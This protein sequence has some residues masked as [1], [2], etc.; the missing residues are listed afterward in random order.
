MPLRIAIG[1]FLHET[2]TFVPPVTPWARFVEPGAWPGFVR[3][4][5]MLPRIEPY[6]IACAGFMAVARA[7]GHEVLPLAWCMAQPSGRVADEAFERVSAIFLERIDAL[8]PDVVFLELHGAMCTETI[9]DAEGELQRRVRALVGPDV[10]ILV[11][12]DLHANVTALMVETASFMSA[13]RTYPHIDWLD[14]GARC[15]RWL[16]AVR[17][18]GP[19]PPRAFRQ[20]PFLIPIASG[21]STIEPMKGLYGLLETIERET[22]VHLSLCPGFPSADIYDSGASV[23][24]YGAN[25]AIVDQAVDR[26]TQAVIKAEPEFLEH[27]ARPL[28]DALD[29]AD[30]RASGA[31]KPILIADSQDNPGG[32]GSSATT[33]F[34]QAM[35]ARSAKRALLA[36][37]HEPEIA[38]AAHAAGIGSTITATFGA[39]IEGPGQEPVTTQAQV[40]A[41]SDGRFLGTGPMVGGQPIVMGPSAWL[42]IGGIDVIVNSVRQQPHCVATVTHLGV[43][44]STYA[45]IVL[46]SSVHFRGDWQPYSASV[47]VGAAPGSLLDDTGIIPYERLRPTVRR[48]PMSN[49]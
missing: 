29:E 38:A 11:S 30:K 36:L 39:G 42:R 32:G 34:L 21:C 10:P 43:D 47:L 12:L 5:E 4:P 46:K 44:I 19:R 15:A 7:S 20:I 8:K 45:V 22:G 13:Y 26:L 25:Q 37:V 6:N 1:G 2:N 28:L 49:Q 17:A 14:T 24:G 23:C 18:W 3:G 33:G 35:I 27:R 31:T 9:D 40:I 48:R 16:D 41:L